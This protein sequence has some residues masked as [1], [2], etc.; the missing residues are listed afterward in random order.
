MDHAIRT[1]PPLDVLVLGAGLAGLRAAW[2]AAE[3]RPGARVAIAMPLAGPS[4]SSFANPHDRLGLHIPADDAAREAFCAEAAALAPPG[5]ILPELVRVLAQ[6]AQARGRELETLG[7]DFLRTE[8]GA[9]RLYPSCFSP[10]SRRAVVFRNLG[11]VFTAMRGKATGQGV[12]LLP[13]LTAV[14]VVQEWENGPVIGALLEDAAG[15]WIAQPARSVIAAMGGP[16]SLFLHHQAGRGATGCGHGILGAA[17]AAMA[18]T[19]YLQWMWAGTD[20]KRFWPVW[21]LL[22]G[23]TLPLDALGRPVPLPEAVRARAAGRPDHCP[24]GHGLADAA[25]DHFLLELADRDGVA[26]VVASDPSRP[27]APHTVALMAHASNGGAVIDPDGRTSIPGLY[28][29]G[30]CATGMHGANRIGGAM[31]AACLVFGARAGRAAVLATRERP[32]TGR[33]FD[34]A[35]AACASRFGRDPKER[36]TAQAALARALQRHG[37]P[38]QTPDT[39]ALVRLLASCRQTVVDAVAAAQIDSALLFARETARHPRKA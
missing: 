19:G 38:R 21:S 23:A 14:A 36:G 26:T 18:N 35:L 31:V 25:L 7:V 11:A 39:A 2:G 22:D 12:R 34:R 10:A 17:G 13:G 30:E 5:L 4:G 29:A 9:P 27:E 3:A 33:E 37:L 24:L 20:S 1:L 16:A 8:T 6:E 32:T 28:A 15:R